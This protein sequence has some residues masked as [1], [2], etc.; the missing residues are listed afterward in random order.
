[1]KL[2]GATLDHGLLAIVPDRL[3]FVA[4]PPMSKAKVKIIAYEG[5]E[6]VAPHKR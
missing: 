1:M 4:K 3:I 5:I 6:K 2:S